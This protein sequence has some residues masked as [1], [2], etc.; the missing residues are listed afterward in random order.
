MKKSKQLLFDDI[1]EDIEDEMDFYE[2]IKIW[3]QKRK[4][5]KGKPVEKK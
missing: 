1:L 5:K 2:T 4:N 3:L